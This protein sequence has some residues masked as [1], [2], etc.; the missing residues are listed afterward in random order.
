MSLST[1]GLEEGWTAH[2]APTGHTY[3]YNAATK[4]STYKRPVKV[5]PVNDIE[6]AVQASSTAQP[7]GEQKSQEATVAELQA[8]S[9]DQ[10]TTTTKPKRPRKDNT[11][12]RPKSKF[13]SEGSLPWIK[14]YTR[15]G[16]HFYHNVDTLESLWILSPELRTTMQEID[17]AEAL[18]EAE[19][20]EGSEIEYEPEDG[21]GKAPQNTLEFG[22]D[23]IDW[24]LAALEEAGMTMPDYG[25]LPEQSKAEKDQL[26]SQMLRDCD[27]NPYNTW[28]AEVSKIASDPRY[29]G[30][31]SYMTV[32]TIVLDS[33]NERKIVFEAYCTERA[34]ELQAIKAATKTQDV[35]IEH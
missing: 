17:D 13:V 19:S 3:Y 23:D 28:D 6:P 27:V 33:T 5:A 30:K 25:D 18:A 31:S 26:F 21:S 35:S 12:D 24:Q 4:K 32:L 22:E 29:L 10:N 14:V 8:I 20:S 11:I 16:Y 2:K 34:Q 1:E 7:S 9:A 15:K